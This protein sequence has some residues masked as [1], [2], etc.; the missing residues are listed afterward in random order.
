MTKHRGNL[1]LKE[2]NT[3][4]MDNIKA[5]SNISIPAIELQVHSAPNSRNSSM[6][7][8]RRYTNEISYSDFLRRN[9]F[10]KPVKKL[11][12]A[13]SEIIVSRLNQQS[14]RIRSFKLSPD[15]ILT[16]CKLNVNA[17][18]IRRKSSGSSVA[19]SYRSRLYSTT[20]EEST[21]SCSSCSSGYY[22]ISIIG[23]SG[24]GKTSLQNR[25]MRSEYMSSQEV[26]KFN[27]IRIC[28]KHT[29][30]SIL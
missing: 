19:S 8:R 18:N 15:G 20:S 9:S 21:N 2:Q 3:V 14:S 16:D 5:F 22:R 30:N 17:T 25:F 24:V 10:P 29:K 23:A 12:R 1:R 4:N 11:S 13:S 26:G 7:K 6:K 28:D 27:K